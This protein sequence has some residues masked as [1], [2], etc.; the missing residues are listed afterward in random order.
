MY[1]HIY[2]LSA[3][4]NIQWTAYKIKIVTDQHTPKEQSDQGLFACFPQLI[5]Y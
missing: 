2:H 5:I 3:I 1:M 4:T